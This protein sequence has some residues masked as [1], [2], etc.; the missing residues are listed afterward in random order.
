MENKRDN[1]CIIALIIGILGFSIGTVIGILHTPE[2]TENRVLE[3]IEDYTP[4]QQTINNYFEI[5]GTR[6]QTIMSAIDNLI[7]DGLIEYVKV[8]GYEVYRISEVI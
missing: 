3:Y 8:G 7:T 6:R 5:Y 2:L 1:I 4:T